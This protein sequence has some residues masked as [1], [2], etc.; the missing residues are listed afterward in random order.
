M[1]Y[2]KIAV[3]IST[4]GDTLQESVTLETN[5]KELLVSLSMY[6]LDREILASNVAIIGYNYCL[7]S[8]TY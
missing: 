6:K 3:D 5:I 1:D 4:L 7:H 2:L 8:Y